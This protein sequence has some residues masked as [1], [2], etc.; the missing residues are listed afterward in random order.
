[1]WSETVSYFKEHLKICLDNLEL[2]QSDKLTSTKLLRDSKL[3]IIG[4]VVNKI[5]QLDNVKIYNSN[6]NQQ[7]EAVRYFNNIYRLIKFNPLLYSDK[8]LVI[9]KYQDIDSIKEIEPYM[10][11]PIINIFKENNHI[12]LS[13]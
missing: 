8:D 13:F 11:K 12:E 9:E 5:L 10:N 3:E 2:T 7:K 4:Y 6:I 1:M